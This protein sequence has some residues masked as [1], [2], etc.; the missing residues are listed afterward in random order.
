M[1]SSGSSGFKMCTLGVA[2]ESPRC[3]QESPAGRRSPEVMQGDRGR[4]SVTASQSYPTSLRGYF[5]QH[6]L[7]LKV[8]LGGHVEPVLSS[9]GH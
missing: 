8:T 1:E 5:L 6:S 4:V 2:R 3:P 9:R 7:A